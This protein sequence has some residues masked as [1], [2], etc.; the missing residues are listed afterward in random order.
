MN[1][2]KFLKHAAAIPV[3]PALS[4]LFAKL[5]LE[6]PKAVSSKPFRRVRPA[7]PDWPSPEQWARLREQVGGRLIPVTSPLAP[8]KD[9]PGS[10]A[11]A[12]R[13]EDMKNPWFIADEV[14]GTQLAGWQDA[15]TSS[16]SFCAVEAQKTEDVVAAVNFARDNRLRLVVKGGGHSYLGTSN[17]PDSLL[18][19][20]KDLRRIA[21]HDDFVPQGCAGTPPRKA[22]SLGAGVRWVQAYDAVTT[23]AGRYVQGGGCCSV[24]VVGLVCGGGFGSFSKHFGMAAASLLEAE[25]VTADGKALVANAC[26]HPNLFWALKGGGGGT[27]GV[28]TR[29]TL[30]THDL[31]EFFGGASG[32]IQAKSDRAYRRLVGEFLR[33]YEKALFN[34]H[35]GEQAIVGPD[36]TLQL[37]MVFADLTDDQAEAAWNPFRKFVAGSPDDFTAVEPIRVGTM[38]ARRWWDYDWRAQHTPDAMKF[39]PRPGAPGGNVWWSGNSGEVN[40]FIHGYE[41]LWMPASLFRDPDRLADTVY[42][43]SRR[44]EVQLHFNKGLAGAPAGAI[45]AARDTPVNPAVLDAFTLVIIATGAP[46]ANPGVAGHEPDAAK[47]RADAGSITVAMEKL[48]AVVPEAASYSNESNYFERGFQKSYWGT[49]HPR[50]ADIKKKYDPDGLFFVHNGIGSEDWSKD[51]FER[52]G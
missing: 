51:G 6:T 38:P 10:A 34:P 32:K 41:S 5:N 21:V 44:F 20:T 13:L 12:A 7:D 22:V 9:A 19:W 31:P 43:G 33:F 16:P 3:L 17:A 26:T 8:C 11:C 27:F 2:R 18:V 46:H 14:G 15:W 49:N 52:V 39:D 30:A 29:M 40:A 35:W 1:R 28:V 25:V 42:E 47:A 45:A 24:G 23:R 50:L 37:H 48:R 36:N 4:P